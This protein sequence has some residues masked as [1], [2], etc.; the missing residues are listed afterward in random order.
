MQSVNK[1]VI[2][3][4]MFIIVLTFAQKLWLMKNVKVHVVLYIVGVRF[5]SKGAE[6]Y[7]VCTLGQWGLWEHC[8][9]VLVGFWYELVFKKERGSWKNSLP[10]D[11]LRGVVGSVKFGKYR[12]RSHSPRRTSVSKLHTFYMIC[13]ISRYSTPIMYNIFSLCAC[14]CFYIMST[15]QNPSPTYCVPVD[16]YKHVDNLS[17]YCLIFLLFSFTSIT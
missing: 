6:Y 8:L 5:A 16:S 4:V 15:R 17:V 1:L 3:D 2:V 14:C 7:I 13:T 9:V 12:V 10:P 11:F